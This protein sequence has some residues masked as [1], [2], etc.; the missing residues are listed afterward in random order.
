MHPPIAGHVKY[1]E[2]EVTRYQDDPTKLT[3]PD[4]EKGQ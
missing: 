2:V 4:A 3:A 1:I